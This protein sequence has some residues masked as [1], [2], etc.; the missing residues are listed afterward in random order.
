MA[1]LGIT[2]EQVAAACDSLMGANRPITIN[3]VREVL[4]TGSPNTV[5]AH[6]VKWRAARPVATAAAYEL[7]TDLVNA[8]GKE[9][10]KAKAAARAEIESTLV[11]VQ[12]EAAQLSAVG[13]TLEQQLSDITEQLTSVASER[14]AA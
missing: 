14:D 5:H 9:M 12:E 6:L 10:A 13:E 7:P 2:Y 3:S 8:F 1:R 4:G 11:T